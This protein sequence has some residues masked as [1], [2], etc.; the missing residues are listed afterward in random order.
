MTTE[1]S[2]PDN[3]TSTPIVRTYQID[4][5]HTL[6]VQGSVVETNAAPQESTPQAPP[7]DGNWPPLLRFAYGSATLLTGEV[8]GR[9]V[10]PDD[11]LA[12]RS[13]ESVLIPESE[14][15]SI[16]SPRPLT[17]ARYLTV[18]ALGDARRAASGGLSTAHGL[19]NTAG[20]MIGRV[21]GPVW[22]SF[23]LAPIRGPVHQWRL[24]GEQQ[25][26]EWIAEGRLE[27]ARS[28]ALAEA[29]LTNLVQESVTDLTE[30]PQIQV[31]VQDV[32]QSQSTS[33]LTQ[34][35]EETRE[36]FISVDMVLSGTLGNTRAQRPDFR[37]HYLDAFAQRRPQY[38]HMNLASTM[39]GTYAGYASRSVAFI[40]DVTLLLLGLAL[41]SAFITNTLSL[42]GA[43]DIVQQFLNSGSVVANISL[44]LLALV[45][46]F[47][48]TSYGVLF[49]TLTGST[50]GHVL[51]GLRVVD[52]SGDR[53]SFWQSIR[54]MIGAYVAGFILFLGFIWPLFDKRRQG[55]HDKIGSTFV[56]Y[57]W[58][59]RPDEN[60]LND[61][62]QEELAEDRQS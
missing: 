39:A 9:M 40:I 53:L 21:A 42:F 47:A 7:A 52:K 18:G 24:R 38:Q 1:S 14:W 56:V 50:P 58:P 49:W 11:E 54:R 45:N 27:E 43:L 12:L 26:K 20:E 44:V 29:S 23:L 30:S 31:L 4:P 59:A 62:V 16:T 15:D 10:V 34:L 3:E 13:P 28:K 17:T 33:I 57:D 32:I 19:T 8:G 35:V 36:R 61:R 37:A 46:F 6:V 48:V 22:R 25:V 2:Q 60:F 41:T 5:E 55:W 51:L